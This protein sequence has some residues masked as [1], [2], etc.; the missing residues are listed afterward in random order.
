[1]ITY[2]EMINYLEML[3]TSPKDDNKLI[4]LKEHNI[5]M[6]GNVMYRYI[7]NVT[8]L[9]KTRLNNA[10]DS[11]IEK[12]KGIKN[13]ENLFSLEVLDLKK[14][15][16]Y[17]LKI[18]NSINIPIDNKNKLRETIKNFANET[19]E[20]LENNTKNIDNTGKLLS[21]IKNHNITKLED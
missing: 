10:I 19:E 9:I 20:I 4:F 13:D 11:F 16:I 8:N 18:V 17:D 15:I 12:I 7:D 6:P 21:I 2:Y 5:D 14:E 1:M 3:K